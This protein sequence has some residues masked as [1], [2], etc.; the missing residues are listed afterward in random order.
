M[1]RSR[2]ITFVEHG[3][4]PHFYF[5]DPNEDTHRHRSQAHGGSRRSREVEGHHRNA[6]YRQQLFGVPVI[7]LVLI[8]E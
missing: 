1:N 4:V 6:G 7:F 2:K 5:R 3:R 8:L